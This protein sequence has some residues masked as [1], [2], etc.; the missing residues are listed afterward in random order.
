MALF[1]AIFVSV[2]RAG[3]ILIGVGI[4]LAIWAF[5]M[6]ASRQDEKT[7]AARRRIENLVNPTICPKAFDQNFDFS[8]LKK[9]HFIV[10]MT[11]SCFG[12]IVHT[13]RAWHTWRTQPSGDQTGFW[14]AIWIVGEGR[15]HG[16]FGPNGQMDYTYN[17]AR[18]EGHG[19]L[20]FYTN[21]V[22]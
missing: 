14:Q 16:P 13:P 1:F 7:A 15:P 19:T 17:Q 12:G 6:L 8:N 4:I 22:P 21:D 9:N 10:P 2:K 11:E 5:G 18:F 20:L 3:S